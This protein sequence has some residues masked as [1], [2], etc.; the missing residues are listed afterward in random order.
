MRLVAK[1]SLSI[2]RRLWI[3]LYGDKTLHTQE[4]VGRISGREVS[5]YRIK[6]A[7]KIGI[8]NRENDDDQD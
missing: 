6:L 1:Y 3:M 2:F 5:M 7:A 4:N 8:E